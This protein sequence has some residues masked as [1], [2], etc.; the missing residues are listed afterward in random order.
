MGARR[1]DQRNLI[2]RFAKWQGARAAGSIVCR[3]DSRGERNCFRDL[4][5]GAGFAKVPLVAPGA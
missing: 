2:T 3:V 1:Q 5:G 4:P